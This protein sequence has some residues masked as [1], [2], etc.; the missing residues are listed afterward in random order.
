MALPSGASQT[1][2][3]DIEELLQDIEAPLNEPPSIAEPGLSSVD[4]EDVEID[5]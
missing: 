3:L 2:D 1:A 5:L 4:L